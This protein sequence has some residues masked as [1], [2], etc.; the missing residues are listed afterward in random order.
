MKTIP[1]TQGF[2]AIVDDADYAA[3]SKFKWHVVKPGRNNY[4]AR[5]LRKGSSPRYQYLHQFLLP[6]A[7]RVDHQD[8]DGLN[9]QRYNL[10]PASNLENARAFR[11]KAASATSQFRGVSWHRG[12]QKWVAQITMPGVNP[13]LGLF[14]TE[15]LAAKAYDRAAQK[16]FGEF[17]VLNFV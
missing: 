12:A 10:R 13:Y 9:C 7:E 1:L 3:V 16:H 6:E 2:V 15:L 4:A 5:N 8:G 14:K 17:A 11:R